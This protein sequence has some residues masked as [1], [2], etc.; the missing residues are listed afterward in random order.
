MVTA[1]EG[2]RV[3]HA[4]RVGDGWRSGVTVVLA[5][6]GGAVGG[7]DVAG[8]APG[9]RETDLLDPRNLVERVD[10]VVLTGGSAFGLAA[11]CGVMEA[12]ADDGRGFRVSP[13]GAVPPV[14]VP[15]V[16][17]AALFD[18]G[19]GGRPRATPTA[20]MGAAAYADA[21]DSGARGGSRA[22]A[23]GSV[24][25]G[26]GAV[27]GGV[28]GGV[29]T[30]ATVLPDGTRVAALAVVNS[31]GSAV[32]PRTGR[33]YGDLDGAL[34]D[35]DP[36][37][38]ARW[39]PPA[40]AALEAGGQAGAHTTIGVVATDATLTKAQCSRLAASA[41][42]GLAIA[43]RPVHTMVDGDTVFALA[44]GRAPLG[45]VNAVLAAAASVFARAVA[46]AVYRADAH[47]AIPSYR[48]ALLARGRTN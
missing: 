4:Q 30:A 10:A 18:L 24:G 31:A 25:A 19:R 47:P 28:A 15:I 11:A 36:D 12:L 42:D 39:R 29:G 37:A 32:D 41:Q 17:A 2:V 3:G 38:L 1:V 33:L 44:T 6:P 43:V 5:P 20:E 13:P 21:R 34:P 46:D 16:P 35:P 40:L 8:G 45:D 7:V 14:V 48:D 22:P 9:T 23:L 26:T 27:S